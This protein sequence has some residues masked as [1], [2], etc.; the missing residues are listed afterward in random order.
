MRLSRRGSR[1][2]RRGSLHIQRRVRAQFLVRLS[3]GR[4]RRRTA[5]CFTGF[6]SSGSS[7]S[8]SCNITTAAPAAATVHLRRRTSAT[9]TTTNNSTVASLPPTL[10]LYTAQTSPDFVPRRSTACRTP[11]PILSALFSPSLIDI[12]Y[13]NFEYQQGRIQLPLRSGQKSESGGRRN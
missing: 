13:T 6:S 7:I 4:R 9:T 10:T 12:K 5:L 8:A 11:S 1:V 3:D 2:L